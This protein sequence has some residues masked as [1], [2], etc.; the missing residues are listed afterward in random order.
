MRRFT[1]LTKA[2]SKKLKNH[3]A[4]VALYMLT[5]NFHRKHMMHG[6]CKDQ[7]FEAGFAPGLIR[8]EGRFS[9]FKSI[10]GM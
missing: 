1:R 3:A 4:S 9:S 5:Y 2:F 8:A 6:Y 7:D 10:P